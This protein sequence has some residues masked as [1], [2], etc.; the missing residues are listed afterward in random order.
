MCYTR[1]VDRGGLLVAAV[2]LLVAHSVRDALHCLDRQQ[3]ED[4]LQGAVPPLVVGLPLGVG[5]HLRVGHSLESGGILG[6]R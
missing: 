3:V 5:L 4:S 2:A 6:L 1:E